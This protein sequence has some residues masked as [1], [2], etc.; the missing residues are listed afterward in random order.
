MVLNE[1]EKEVLSIKLAKIRI[2]SADREE[3]NPNVFPVER[4]YEKRNLEREQ[5]KFGPVYS[6][7]HFAYALSE[8][9]AFAQTTTD[10]PIIF[11]NQRLATFESQRWH[12]RAIIFSFPILLS[13]T[14]F[15]EAPA[16]PREYYLLKHQDAV[17]AE[18]FLSS[19]SDWLREDDERFTSVAIGYLY[20]AMLFGIRPLAF[21][22]CTSSRCA[23]FNSHWQSEMLTAQG[24]EALCPTHQEIWNC[25]VKE[26]VSTPSTSALF[27]G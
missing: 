2:L 26:T 3:L 1:K 9:S 18:Q 15:R 6:G 13:T 24:N 23:L 19:R 14:G 5:M 8:S 27:S 22:F 10:I 7:Y 4:D 21:S 16:R 17:L 20:Q 12:L 11:T 25:L